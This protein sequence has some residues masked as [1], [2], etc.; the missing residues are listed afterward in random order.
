MATCK[1]LSNNGAWIAISRNGSSFQVPSSV[2]RELYSFNPIN[3]KVTEF[4]TIGGHHVRRR[5]VGAEPT[6]QRRSDLMGITLR[7]MVDGCT[8]FLRIRKTPQ[9]HQRY[10]HAVKQLSTSYKTHNSYNPTC[11][12]SYKT[13]YEVPESSLRGLYLDHLKYLMKEMNFTVKFFR[14]HDG[15]WGF[16]DNHTD[17]W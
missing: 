11:S 15:E 10:A 16:F 9:E 17:T 13:F 5:L 6:I 7:V 4:Y 1:G 8:P 2:N 3:G 12:G 14:R